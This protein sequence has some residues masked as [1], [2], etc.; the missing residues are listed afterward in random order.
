M[1]LHRQ[2]HA[3][4]ASGQTPTPAQQSAA[5]EALRR[6]GALAAVERAEALIATAFTGRAKP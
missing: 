3:L 2:T 4:F 5:H 6:R 1:T